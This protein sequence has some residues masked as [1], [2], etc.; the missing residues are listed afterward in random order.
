MKMKKLAKWMSG[1]ALA[2]I[3]ANSA[4]AQNNTVMTGARYD[5]ENKTTRQETVATIDQGKIWIKVTNPMESGIND[6]ENS[7]MLA[8]FGHGHINAIGFRTNLDGSGTALAV[9]GRGP[10]ISDPEKV[11]AQTYALGLFSNE[12]QAVCAG[13]TI[14]SPMKF[15]NG[16]TA[17]ITGVVANGKIQDIPAEVFHGI[18]LTK[19]ARFQGSGIFSKG[20]LKSVSASV[21]IGF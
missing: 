1:A 17:E 13:G 21:A 18:N 14:V 2:L 11:G 7:D 15:V 6:A 8:L 9:R 4:N 10:M 3:L 16:L 20:G 19:K 5:F 12:I